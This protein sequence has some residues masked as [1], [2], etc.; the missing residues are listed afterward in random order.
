MLFKT[1]STGADVPKAFSAFPRCPNGDTAQ[2]Q[3]HAPETGAPM[4]QRQA[5]FLA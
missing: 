3:R 5:T 4:M 2:C 1:R